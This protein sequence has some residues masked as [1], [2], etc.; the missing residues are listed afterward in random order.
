MSKKQAKAA[1]PV[2]PTPEPGPR[3]LVITPQIAVSIQGTYPGQELYVERPN[4][5][6]SRHKVLLTPENAYSILLDILQEKAGEIELERQLREDQR[7]SA[8]RPRKQPDW[9]L[10]AK[11]PEAIII[12]RLPTRSPALLANKSDQTL[13][14][15]GL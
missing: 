8:K 1:K 7:R 13:E 9:T 2:Q 11:H 12:E 3:P 14:E 15:M 10:I 6:G 5:S 4:Q